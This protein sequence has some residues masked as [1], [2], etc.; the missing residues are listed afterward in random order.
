MGGLAERRDPADVIV[1][2]YHHCPTGASGSA[3]GPFNAISYW[4][5][6]INRIRV[7]SSTDGIAAA[8]QDAVVEHL[9][10]SPA[11]RI[12]AEQDAAAEAVE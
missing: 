4:W 6:E 9:G 2:V 1:T 7:I 11:D 8:V 12:R 10:G 3:F 5:A